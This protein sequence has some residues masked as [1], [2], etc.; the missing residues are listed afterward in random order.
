M[1]VASIVSVAPYPFLL[2]IDEP[3]AGLDAHGIA[4]V[5]DLM[6]EARKKGIA[7]LISEHRKE[8]FD[9]DFDS[10]LRLP[11]NLDEVPILTHTLI[12]WKHN[13]SSTK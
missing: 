3:L 11:Y 1:A 7:L 5:F 10:V 13:R 4:R 12:R 2:M 6:R 8:I 9:F